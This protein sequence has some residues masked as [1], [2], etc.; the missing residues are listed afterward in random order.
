MKNYYDEKITDSIN[1]YPIFDM[2]MFL[3]DDLKYFYAFS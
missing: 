1:N 3:Y 2:Y